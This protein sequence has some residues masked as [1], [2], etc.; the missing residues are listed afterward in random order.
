[1]EAD[2]FYTVG[3]DVPD[4]GFVPEVKVCRATNGIAAN[5]LDA[6]MRRRDPECMVI[7][8]DQNTDKPT[9]SKRF[10]HEFD[11]LRNETIQWLKTQPIGCF[12]FKSGVPDKLSTPL[13]LSSQRRVLCSWPRALAGHHSRPRST[14]PG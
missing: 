9:F 14:R 12:F 4:R 11:G 1:M 7:A 3:Y 6:Y 2:G 10:G 13:R 5:Y 8:D